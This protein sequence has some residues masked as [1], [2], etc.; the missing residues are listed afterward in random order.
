MSSK[1]PLFLVLGGSLVAT[2]VSAVVAISNL[3]KG[4]AGAFQSGQV[5]FGA[6][7]GMLFTVGGT[8]MNLDSITVR[9]VDV[10]SSSQTLT[11]GLYATSAGLPTGSALFTDFTLLGTLGSGNNTFDAFSN[12]TLEANTTYAFTVHGSQGLTWGVQQQ[13][14]GV[15]DGAL[16]GWAMEDPVQSFNG[17]ASWQ[18]VGAE[19]AFFASGQIDVSPVPE[20]HEYALV[21]GLGLVGFAF[22]RRRQNQ[23]ASVPVP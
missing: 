5:S 16:A 12:F 19:G 10:S 23:P 18:L 8:S 21:F 22:W 4:D 11:V 20:P 15:D 7:G 1:L 2:P 6:T 9:F 13:S 14:A 17:G 3:G